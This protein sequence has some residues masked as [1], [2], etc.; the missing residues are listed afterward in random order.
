MTPRSVRIPVALPTGVAEVSG[1]WA[2]VPGAT[3]TI[4]LAHGAGAG[5][6]HPFLEGLASALSDSG[7]AV[8]RFVFPYVDAGRRMPGPA[9]H[10]VATWAGVQGWLESEGVGAFVAVGKSYGG[11]MASVATA[12]GAATP[13]A[14]VYLG[15]PLHAPGRPDKPRAE[16]LPRI[17]VP[18]LF[19]EGENDPFIAPREQFEDVVATCHDARVH[20]IEG[21]DHSFAVKGKRRPAEEIGAGLAGVV[22]E[23]VR[24][25]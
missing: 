22:G 1:L 10:A 24:G 19:V 4:A 13:Q 23:F 16:H 7:I 3:A 17:T 8:L 5:M 12:D 2:D 18:Q 6:T 21:A 11:R 14:L 15:Y 20:W 9:A 25:L